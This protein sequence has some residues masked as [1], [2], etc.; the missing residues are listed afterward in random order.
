M[1][2][3]PDNNAPAPSEAAAEEVVPTAGVDRGSGG[4][5]SFA[6]DDYN[7]DAEPA[8]GE[9]AAA[10]AGA[11]EDAETASGELPEETSAGRVDGLED[12]LAVEPQLV[13]EEPAAAALESNAEGTSARVGTGTSAGATAEAETGAG[14]G[15]EALAGETAAGASTEPGAVGDDEAFVDGV[16]LTG[17][18]DPAA[19]PGSADAA[20]PAA[21]AAS[22]D[23]GVPAPAADTDP[24][25]GPGPAAAPAPVFA[26]APAPAMTGTGER[27]AGPGGGGFE[28][29]SRAPR[30]RSAPR[31]ER[32]RAGAVAGRAGEPGR[33]RGDAPVAAAPGAGIGAGAGAVLPAASP[34][35][36]EEFSPTFEDLGL[37]GPLLKSLK[38]VGYEEPTPI[39]VRVIPAL[40]GGGDVIAQAQTGSGKTAAFGLPIIETIDPRLRRPQALILCPTREL[41][42]QVAEA[43]HKY[44]RHKEVE[45]LPIYGGQPYERQF[46]GLQR[47]IQIVVGTPGRVMDHMRR[48]TLVLD[49]LRF[50][51]LDEADEML[52]MGFIDDIEWILEQVPAERQTALFS[53]TMPPRIV[54][55]AGQ[56]MRQPERITVAGREMTVPETH[57]VF[58]EVPRSRKID[59]LTRILDAETPTS[60]MIFCRTKNGVDELG[61]ALMA[62]GYGV[63]TLH[64]DL[65]QVQRDRVMRR[66]RSGQ[67]DI[68]IATDVAARGLDI[69]DVSHVFNFDIPDSAEAYVHRIGRTGRAGRAGVAVT[70]IA[71]RETRWL[72]QIERTTRARIESRRLPT[73][74]D[75]AER[76]RELLKE[77]VQA[78]LGEEDAFAQ[79]LETINDLAEDHDMSA[80]AAAILKLY[81]DETGRAMTPEQE[82]DDLATLGAA[83]GPGPSPGRGP[84][85]EAGMVRL[86]LQVGR[87][88]S[89]RPQ[90]IVGAIA[91]EAQIPGRAI[92]AIDILDAY[93]FVDI[94]QEFVD[95][96]LGAMRSVKI[97]GRF[98]NPEVA[99]PGGEPPRDFD[100]RR[101]GGY[102]RGS[103]RDGARGGFDR[104]PRGDGGY[105]GGP[106]RG[107]FGQQGGAPRGGFGQ[108]GGAPRA[109]FDR[110]GGT[111]R[112]PQ[113]GFDN[114]PRGGF[115]D[116]AR[117]EGRPAPRSFDRGER[118]PFPP[119]RDVPERRPPSVGGVRV[120][121]R[122][123]GNQGQGFP[124]RDD[125]GRGYPRRDEGGSGSGSGG[126][127]GGSGFQ[128]RSG[129]PQL[130]P[131]DGEFSESPPSGPP[132]AGL[133]PGDALP[134][135]RDRG[136]SR[137]RRFERT[138]PGTFKRRSE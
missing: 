118:T 21:P 30:V 131:R 34:V 23:P 107:G 33:E 31:A 20:L 36:D 4:V 64:G 15:T 27:P 126:A 3:H 125:G 35:V 128:E 82:E 74:A 83:V 63:E 54:A 22:E 80:V 136:S 42:I 133:G 52:D 29:E 25:A 105:R 69:P 78:V 18:G 124:R 102:D 40:L 75:V 39:Q 19:A 109:G 46:R 138:G 68:L 97:K 123:E 2:D 14:A 9:P 57:Q 70:L 26:P 8:G 114:A 55:L 135:A 86:V 49:D 95:K 119:R 88:A 132:D 108:Q 87:N 130:G 121:P 37:S 116:A 129:P 112:G 73:L 47:G 84:R 58:Y 60:A 92:G 65:S 61:E 98:V 81:A 91:N 101:G 100:E 122:D 90:D 117:D 134:P 6:T 43:L 72:R 77:Q 12:E 16:D 120:G 50:F 1:S 5:P 93:T 66:F 28:R 7:L 113:G 44:G 103:R 13:A 56:H 96:V 115:D 104:G 71:P 24:A 51:V 111:D 62:R 79:Y 38:D 127:G 106:D 59:A 53:A 32:E 41:A 11:F 85:G 67:A 17:D 110:Q 137:P 45:T 89:V 10:P 76:R 99:R 48:N 94:P